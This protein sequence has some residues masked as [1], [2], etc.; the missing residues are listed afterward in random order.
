MTCN[1]PSMFACEAHYRD[2]RNSERNSGTV[3]AA[4]RRTGTAGLAR[5]RDTEIAAILESSFCTAKTSWLALL[6]L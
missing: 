1:D 5:C 2:K 6:S 3:I 4:Q